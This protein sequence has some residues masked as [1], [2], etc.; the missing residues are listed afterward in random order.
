MSIIPKGKPKLPSIEV[1][2]IAMEMGVE[3]P[4]HGKV[5]VLAIR[6]YYRDSIGKPGKGDRNTY[7]DAAWVI[8]SDR[9]LPFNFS[10]DPSAY[11]RGMASLVP[12]VYRYIP[13]KHKIKSPSGYAAFRQLGNVKVSRDD[14][15]EYTGQFGIN[16]HRGGVFGTSSL[17]CQTVPPFQWASFRDAVYDA[18]GTD[19]KEVMRFPG[20]VPGLGFDY[21]LVT[22]EEAERILGRKL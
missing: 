9:C 17:G 2:K 20:G 4:A 21:I 11:R 12:G 1:R 19:T 22:R 16:I 10:S 18:L 6:D 13:G 14:E 5:A 8:L 15:G 7:D 3:I